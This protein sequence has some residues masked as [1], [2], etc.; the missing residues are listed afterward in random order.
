MLNDELEGNLSDMGRGIE[1]TNMWLKVN[2]KEPIYCPPENFVISG[3]QYGQ[4]LKSTVEK[5]PSVGSFDVQYSGMVL[6]TGLR[7]SFPCQ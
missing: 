3:K 5:N 4:I 6:I 2:D 1:V 7:N